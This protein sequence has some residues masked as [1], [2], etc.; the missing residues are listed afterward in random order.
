MTIADNL[1]R[2]R[3]KAG[4]SQPEL[5]RKAGVTQQ[6]VSQ[7]ETGKNFTTRTL[8][9]LA[10]ALGVTV[11][12]IDPNYV[13]GALSQSKARAEIE[14]I[15]RELED[16]PDLEEQL[17]DQARLLEARARKARARQAPLPAGD[18]E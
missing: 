1:K 3:L 2:L 12:K 15:Y 5:A 7:I 4:L 11:D 17:L 9:Q 14:R 10:T 16:F 6:L 13:A 18:P 8:P